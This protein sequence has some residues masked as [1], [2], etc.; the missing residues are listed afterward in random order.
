MDA[1]HD[2]LYQ[3]ALQNRES[4]TWSATTME[5]ILALANGKNGF[6]KTMWCGDEACELA[7]K[8]QA[9][10]TSRCMP[11]EQE[12]LGDVCPICGKPAKTMVVWGK[13]Y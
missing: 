5:E 6:I 7:M 1:V 12:H 3:R 11:F 9:G 8:E 4:R 13:A 2:G 10:L